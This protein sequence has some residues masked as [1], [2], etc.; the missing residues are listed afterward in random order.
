MKTVLAALLLALSGSASAQ[1]SCA[2]CRTSAGEGKRKCDA[3]AKAGAAYEKCVKQANESMLSCEMGACK[4]GADAQTAVNCP[5]CQAQVADEERRCKAMP[6]GSVEQVACA[7]RAG[8]MRTG[9]DL[10][11]CKPQ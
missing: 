7:Q 10:K 1:D 5:D 2:E 4:P 6:P 9:C 8:R 3:L 11:Y